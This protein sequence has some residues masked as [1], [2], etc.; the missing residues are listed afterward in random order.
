MESTRVGEKALITGHERRRPMKGKS[1]P[2]LLSA[3]MVILALVMLLPT[4][5][6]AQGQ[7]TQQGQPTQQGQAVPEPS[8]NVLLM[9]GIG[10][11]GL[12]GYGLQHRKRKA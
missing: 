5:S 12:V 11:S 10:V 9:I 8:P 6:Q 4:M 2:I 1:R 7:L 3:I